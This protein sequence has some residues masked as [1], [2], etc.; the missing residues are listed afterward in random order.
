MSSKIG[1]AL[2]FASVLSHFATFCSPSC[3]NGL[4]NGFLAVDS[5]LIRVALGHMTFYHICL[6]RPLGPKKGAQVTNFSIW[7]FAGL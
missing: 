3:T 6:G 5:H 4:L 1:E 2:V 7:Y